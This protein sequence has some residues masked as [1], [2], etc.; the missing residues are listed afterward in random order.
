MLRR[1][2]YDYDYLALTF[3]AFP[4]RGLAF[5]FVRRPIDLQTP[6]LLSGLSTTYA[7]AM[8][9]VATLKVEGLL[10]DEVHATSRREEGNRPRLFAA[11]LFLRGVS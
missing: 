3:A 6:S 11:L 8:P 10:S 1:G 7:Y 4:S 9:D 2:V 5:D